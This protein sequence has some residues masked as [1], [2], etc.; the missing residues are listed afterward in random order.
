MGRAHNA[1]SIKEADDEKK[2][3]AG[4]EEGGRE[5]GKLKT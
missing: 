5:V 4:Q 1:I 3:W 2:G